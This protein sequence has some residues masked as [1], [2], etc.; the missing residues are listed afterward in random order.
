MKAFFDWFISLFTLINKDPEPRENNNGEV[1]VIKPEI[2]ALELPKIEDFYLADK[3]RYPKIYK[4]EKD[5]TTGGTKIYPKFVILHHTVSYALDST[6]EYF[7]TANVSV[8]YVV[9]LD[10]KIV[11]MAE[12]DRLCWHAGKSEWKG[13]VGL[14]AHS[15]GIEVVNIGYLKKK[16]DKLFDYYEREF[17][18]PVH[19]RKGIGFEFWAAITP[20]QEKATLELCKYLHQA[21]SI[22]IENF[23]GHYEVSPGRK[24]DPFGLFTFGEMKQVREHMKSIF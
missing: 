16:G 2:P 10:G 6:I 8:H 22:P 17:K 13:L 1:I 9:G 14:N 24:N 3:L 21:L 5:L 15:I 11:Q 23:L 19:I 20:E 4:F 12:N 18:G 7:K